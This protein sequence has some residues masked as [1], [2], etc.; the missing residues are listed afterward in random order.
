MISLQVF[1]QTMVEIG[2][3]IRLP[4]LMI[5]AIVTIIVTSVQILQ[6]ARATLI[7]LLIKIVRSIILVTLQLRADLLLSHLILQI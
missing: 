3:R 7:L 5:L 1:C 4:E 2:G 6:V